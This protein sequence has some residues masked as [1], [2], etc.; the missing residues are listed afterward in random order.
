MAINQLDGRLKTLA[1]AEF[2][3]MFGTAAEQL[4]QLSSLRR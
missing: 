4:L 3:R 2:R 1:I